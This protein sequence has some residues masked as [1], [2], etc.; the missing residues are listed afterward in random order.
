MELPNS[1]SP[2][3]LNTPAS[4]PPPP[5]ENPPQQAPLDPIEWL[6]GLT[7]GRNQYFSAGAGLFAL[8]VFTKFW[9]SGARLVGQVARKRFLV[10]LE[11]TN[12]DQCYSAMLQLIQS[13]SNARQISLTSASNKT[14][15]NILKSEY[16]FAYQPEPGL[17]YFMH[18]NKFFK[19][20]RIR[21][22]NQN[23]HTGRPFE[24][25]KLTTIG[26][27]SK[28]LSQIIDDCKKIANK[29][30][31]KPYTKI[32]TPRG[33]DWIKLGQEKTQRKLDSIF[34]EPGLKQS[35]VSD[36][37]NFLTSQD[38]YESC[39]VP[40]KRS[41]LFHGPPGC[42]KT[43][44]IMAIAGEMNLNVGIINLSEPGLGDERLF[45]LF[46]NAPMNTVL[47]LE[48]IDHAFNSSHA[49]KSENVSASQKMPGISTITFSGLLNALDGVAS[50][51]GIMIFMT[52]NNYAGLN[53]ALVRPG[54]MD[55][56]CYFG[57]CCLSMV[58]EMYEH[59]YKNYFTDQLP[60]Y[61]NEF[62][63]A[64]Q[65]SGSAKISPARLQEFFLKY[66]V[67]PFQALRNIGELFNAETKLECLD[68]KIK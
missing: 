24:T 48:D 29:E 45:Y 57:K 18:K 55:L 67:N 50:A 62:C 66:K 49:P 22:Q 53:P 17:H 54:R 5:P 60:Y 28:V 6:H 46:A 61:S 13:K 3:Q 34:L 64:F 32:F 26:L 41:Y 1:T 11:I 40:Y 30:F 39:G 63:K 23:F 8:G 37:K 42:G 9:A 43:S 14:R 51:H 16:H 20:E 59:F 68:F 47:V 31:S 7:S 58:K 27:N 19:V 21:S 10:S 44:T 12:Q 25:L 2:L 56:K 4:L 36:L 15:N 38:W 35:I 33:P 65:N 52:T